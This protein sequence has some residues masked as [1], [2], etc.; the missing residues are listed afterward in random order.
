MPKLNLGRS[1][2]Q[3][4][5]IARDSQDLLERLNTFLEPSARHK[6]FTNEVLTG[7]LAHRFTPDQIE[8]MNEQVN[9]IKA[10]LDTKKA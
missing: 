6:L 9:E 10:L 5:S 2:V 1:K 4:G 8:Q 3:L 7:Q